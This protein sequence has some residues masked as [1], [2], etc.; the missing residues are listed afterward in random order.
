METSSSG[1][2]SDVK[3]RAAKKDA[4]RVMRLGAGTR[5]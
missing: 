1:E 3:G 2:L 5:V 4:E